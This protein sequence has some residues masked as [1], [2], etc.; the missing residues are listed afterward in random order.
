MRPDWRRT[1]IVH[2]DNLEVKSAPSTSK[3]V[4]VPQIVKRSD[5]KIHRV[6]C[7]PPVMI[8]AML[9]GILSIITLG[10]ATIAYLF[11]KKKK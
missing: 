7:K 10:L 8:R 3:K 4:Q 5:I 1:I 11:Y 2:A 9:L 6:H